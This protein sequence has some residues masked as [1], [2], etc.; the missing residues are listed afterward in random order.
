[1]DEVPEDYEVARFL[2]TN[3]RIDVIVRDGTGITLNNRSLTTLMVAGKQL[4]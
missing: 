1:M 2:P 4:L 3:S